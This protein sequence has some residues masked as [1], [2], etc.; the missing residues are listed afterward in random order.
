MKHQFRKRLLGELLSKDSI[1]MQPIVAASIASIDND[2][3][4]RI[5]LAGIRRLRDKTKVLKDL[6]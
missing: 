6:A 1:K 5:A 3:T 2:V 4:K